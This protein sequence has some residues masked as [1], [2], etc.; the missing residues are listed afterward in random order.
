MR[1]QIG[2]I[3]RTSRLGVEHAVHRTLVN[4]SLD[5]R[6]IDRSGPRYSLFSFLFLTFLLFLFFSLSP[7]LFFF[8]LF[9]F[10]GG[11]GGGVGRFLF[12]IRS[13]IRY[14]DGVVDGDESFACAS[15]RRRSTDPLTPP[16]S[17]Y[18][19]S[20]QFQLSIETRS[21]GLRGRPPTI[22]HTGSRDR[23]KSIIDS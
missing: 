7:F 22:P 8:F 19:S 5:K 11:G 9:W 18:S 15:R 20:I 10:P 3:R 2:F 6:S 21:F 13:R 14:A 16:P 4:G 17:P 23:V 12:Y 1:A